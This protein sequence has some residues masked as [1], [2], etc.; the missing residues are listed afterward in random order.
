MY[1]EGKETQS[2]N[3]E[4]FVLHLLIFFFNFISIRCPFLM[5]VSVRHKIKRVDD[6]KCSPKMTY[7]SQSALKN[8]SQTSLIGH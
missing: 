4:N 3:Q 8:G 2:K 7:T 6:Q 1:S 5:L